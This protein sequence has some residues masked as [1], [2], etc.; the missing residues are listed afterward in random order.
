MSNS[1]EEGVMSARLLVTEEFLVGADCTYSGS[2][3]SL[4]TTH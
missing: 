1:S 3:V 4:R 2:R